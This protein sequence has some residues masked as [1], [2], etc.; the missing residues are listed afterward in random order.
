MVQWQTLLK[1]VML[2]NKDYIRI[3]DFLKFLTFFQHSGIKDTTMVSCSP[4]VSTFGVSLYLNVH[5]LSVFIQS[6]YINL[7]P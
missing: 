1:F 3:L 2:I 5:F 6:M 7:L 4:Y